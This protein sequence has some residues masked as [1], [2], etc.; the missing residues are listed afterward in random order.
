LLQIGD[1]DDVT[2]SKEES[3][4]F[5]EAIEQAIKRDVGEIKSEWRGPNKNTT[6]N[7]YWTVHH[8]NS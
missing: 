4:E 3:E 2:N 8:C 7:V 6:S 1:K 5:E